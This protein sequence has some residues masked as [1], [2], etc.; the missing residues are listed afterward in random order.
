MPDREVMSHRFMP[1]Y[2][3]VY[4]SLRE[5]GYISGNVKDTTVNQNNVVVKLF[6]RAPYTE[7]AW[8]RTDASGNFRF[9][10]LDTT[11]TYCVVMVDPAGGATNNLA[12]RDYVAPVAY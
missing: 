10:K 6:W 4:Q 5:D 9:D 11:K 7:I 8:T 1:A 12:R 2:V 3:D